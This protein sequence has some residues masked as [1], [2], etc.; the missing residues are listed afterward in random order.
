MVPLM[1]IVE[2]IKQLVWAVDLH[3]QVNS[4]SL[5]LG[6]RQCLTA[7]QAQLRC[8]KYSIRM[9]AS[10]AASAVEDR[11]LM[12]GTPVMSPTKSQ[13]LFSVMPSATRERQ[14]LRLRKRLAD[15]LPLQ[16]RSVSC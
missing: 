15:D 5:S 7:D 13:G 9:T 1:R 4:P 3:E 10:A 16:I 6:L 8:R 2:R 14:P 11:R 12:R